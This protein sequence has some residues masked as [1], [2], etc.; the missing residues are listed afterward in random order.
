MAELVVRALRSIFGTQQPTGDQLAQR[1]L[2]QV[3]LPAQLVF[4]EAQAS[5]LGT[6]Q[7]LLAQAAAGAA[8]MAFR[9]AA[10]GLTIEVA[11]RPREPLPRRRGPPS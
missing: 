2:G 9:K 6:D 7:V 8:A 10:D 3:E 5:P 1:F 11:Q 4:L